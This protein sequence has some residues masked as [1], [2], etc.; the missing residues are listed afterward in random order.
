MSFS[1]KILLGLGLGVLA[2]LFLGERAAFLQVAAD[3]YVKLLQM[4]VLPYVMVSIVSGL[5]SLSF[6]QART[7]GVRAGAVLLLLWMLALALVFVFPLM[8][9]AME[10]ASF[11]STTLLE[12]PERF[13]LVDLYIPANPFHSLANNVVPA[14]VL[15]SLVLGVALIGI[16][17]KARLL[18]VL[19]V[20]SEAVSRATSYIVRL[21]PYGIFAIAATAAGTLSIEQIER[22]EVYFVSYIAVSL[23]ASLWILPGLVAALTPVPYRAVL[24][25]MRDAL[26]TAFMTGN[27]FIVLPILSEQSK[28]LARDHGLPEEQRDAPDVIVPASFNFPHTGKLLTLS[29]ILFAGWFSDAAVAAGEYP[30]LALTGLVVLIGNINVAVPFLLDLFRIPADTFQLFL[31]SGVV[32]GRF[33]TLIAAMHTVAMALLG[34]WAIAGALR[35]ER[36]RLVRYAVVSLVL[37][38]V[39][40]GGVR[41]VLSG[42]VRGGY[43][44]QRILAGMRPILEPAPATVYRDAAQPEKESAPDRPAL[45]RIRGSGALRVGYLPDSLPFAYFNASGDLV[46]FDVE[47]AHQLARELGVRLEFLPV[48]RR[49]LTGAL[50]ECGCDLVMSGVGVTTERAADTLFSTAYL[51]ETL[52]FVVADHLRDRFASW[53]VIRRQGRL[54]LGVPNLPYYLRKV[55]EE[56]PQ[57]D[58]TTF[59]SAEALFGPDGR[60][61]DA[62]V[63]TAERGSAWT[64]LHPELSVV[65]PMPGVIRVPLAYPIAARDSGLARLINTWIDLKRKDGTIQVLYNHWILGRDAAPARPRWSILRN[66][67][68]WVD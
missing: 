45:E 3:G 52:A 56:L 9:P 32:N 17:R 65:V 27:L 26:I 48:E 21:T 37:T 5:G 40:V 13:N 43:Q 4:T 18:E 67:L 58:I 20:V 22:L 1:K 36:H 8:F 44:G 31:A 49:A 41:A 50:T 12:P 51:D 25:S 30:Q 55:S 34:T 33:G 68:H 11:F 57:A 64:L 29:F 23:L 61:L 46:G 60:A 53:D 54:R 2:G 42:L 38:A 59:D 62:L 15:F 47:M 66:V 24:G 63:A 10:T 14:V 35:F 6:A 19:A 7:L 39:T 16:S 28:R